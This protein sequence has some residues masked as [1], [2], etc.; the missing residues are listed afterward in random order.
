MRLKKIDVTGSSN[1]PESAPET[2]QPEKHRVLLRDAL[3]VLLDAIQPPPSI[4]PHIEF[5][6]DKVGDAQSDE[7]PRLIY[8]IADIVSECRYHFEQERKQVEGYLSEANEKFELLER[9][10]QNTEQQTQTSFQNAQKVGETIDRQVHDMTYRLRRSS[11]IE[12]LAGWLNERLSIV[13]ARLE[14]YQEQG[15]Q[16]NTAVHAQLQSVSGT[17]GAMTENTLELFESVKS[18]QGESPHDP[19]DPLTDVGGRAQLEE[20]VREQL[21]QHHN[22]ATDQPG[23]TFCYQLWG[24][25]DLTRINT[26]Y[27]RQVGNRTLDVVAQL[28]KHH[29]RGSDVIFRYGSDRFVVVLPDTQ[30]KEAEAVASRL[31]RAIKDAD[32]NHCGKTV[33]ITISGGYTVACQG[34][35]PQ[36]IYARAD[37]ALKKAKHAGG[38]QVCL[39]L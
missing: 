6:K 8:A 29:L 3:E 7:L 16:A 12:N 24:V 26:T 13:R 31:H 23:T 28:L 1:G 17:L 4:E 9:A 33:S 32:F 5:L 22:S 11:N 36:S 35:S 30:D 20:I 14:E 21:D 38:D 39:I 37:E 10:L 15:S 18:G 25:D 27:G 2:R 19:N 34:D